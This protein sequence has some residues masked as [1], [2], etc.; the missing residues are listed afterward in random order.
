MS[1]AKSEWERGEQCRN[2]QKLPDDYHTNIKTY[3][4]W[5]QVKAAK[6]HKAAAVSRRS[7]LEWLVKWERMEEA[8]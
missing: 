5:T 7:E 6:A 2:I 3:K 8:K 1:R 4:T